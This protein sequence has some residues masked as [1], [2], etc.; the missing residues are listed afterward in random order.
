[1]RGAL[2]VWL[3]DAALEAW[4]APTSGRPAGQRTYSDLAVET[5]LTIRMVSHLPLRQ[6]EGFLRS[7]ADLLRL[8][9]EI[10]HAA[11]C[12]MDYTWPTAFNPDFSRSGEI[13]LA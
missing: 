5:A 3:S 10:G 8:D 2:T 6:A 4:R 12:N 1:M 11:V 9:G 7:L 13:P